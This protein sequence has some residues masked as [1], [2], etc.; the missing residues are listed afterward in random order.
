MNVLVI[1]RFRKRS[2]ARPRW[3]RKQ[4]PPRRPT[5]PTWVIS[6]YTRNARGA[7]S[8]LFFPSPFPSRSCPR[9]SHDP[10]GRPTRE[11]G[12]PEMARFG[13]IYKPRAAVLGETSF[14]P[15][16]ASLANTIIITI[17]AVAVIVILR[18]TIMEGS[19][20]Y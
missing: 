7:A 17:N 19:F 4:K 10:P 13:C 1:L 16:Y 12:F 3:R 15:L 11:T 9:L 14:S 5:P 8:L 18:R 20:I 2:P 6:S